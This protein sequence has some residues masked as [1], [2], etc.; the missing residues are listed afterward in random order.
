MAIRLF[1]NGVTEEYEPKN[2]VFTDNE[3]I[4]PFKKYDS[5]RTVRLK[6]IP[7]VW[8]LFGEYKKPDEDDYNH[9]GSDIVEYHCYSPVI[10]IHDTEINP[11]WG[12]T[13]TIYFDYARFKNEILDFLDEI[14]QITLDEINKEQEENGKPNL[15]T[16]EHVGVSED[17][18][19]IFNLSPDKQPIEFYKAPN[20]TEFAN[21][22]YNFLTTSYKIGPIF[23]IFADKRMIIVIEDADVE[24]F[25]NKLSN[26]YQEREEYLKCAEINKI[27]TKWVEVKNNVKP[28]KTTKKKISE[29]TL[30]KK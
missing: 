20:F 16:L 26:N 23:A 25:I 6:E 1:E 30:K 12:V 21:K 22:C 28:K 14:A 29:K 8:C 2:H 9:L 27:Y 24:K 13:E 18:R 5:L 11:D 15:M 4:E 7:N 3:L 19:I 17:K 10:F